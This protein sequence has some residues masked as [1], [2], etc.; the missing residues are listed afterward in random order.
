MNPIA[1][2]LFQWVSL[3]V[4]AIVLTA[5]L[6]MLARGHV[7][8]TLWMLRVLSWIGMAIAIAS[9]ASMTRLAQALDIQRGADLVSYVGIVAFVVV[10]L[11]LYG[12]CL[13]LQRQITEVARYVAIRDAKTPDERRLP[14]AGSG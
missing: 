9:P 11:L 12:Q 2:N 4:L 1:F 13:H 14:D 3:S 10:S 8:R 7:R 6:V 5:E